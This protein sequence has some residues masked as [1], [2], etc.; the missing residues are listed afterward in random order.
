MAYVPRGER[1]D[2]RNPE[3]ASVSPSSDGALAR[4]PERARRTRR[5]GRSLPHR[6]S[7]SDCCLAPVELRA[8]DPQCPNIARVPNRLASGVGRY[9]FRSPSSFIVAGSSTA[10]TIVA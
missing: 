7:E 3:E 9:Q 10:R 2:F 8:G 5:S 6:E 4:R 1:Q